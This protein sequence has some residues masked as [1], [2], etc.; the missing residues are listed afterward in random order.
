MTQ[1]FKNITTTDRID[2]GLLD[3]LDRDLTALTAMSGESDPSTIPTDA[4][5]DN[6]T[7]GT[8][9]LN[10]NVLIDYKNQLL[11][12]TTLAS[13]FQHLNTNLTAI[14]G[15]TLDVPCLIDTGGEVLSVSDYGIYAANAQI[16]G[17]TKTLAKKSII[18][19][20][21]IDDNSITQ[22]KLEIPLS[23][24]A[25]FKC[26]D[27]LYSGV[28]IERT[29]FLKLGTNYTLGSNSSNATYRNNAYYNLYVKL[30]AAASAVIR[31]YNG[32][33]VNKG[34]SAYDD[35]SNGNSVD[36][37]S[38]KQ[39]KSSIVFESDIPGDY[40]V[41][42]EFPGRYEV[43]CV[44]GGGGTVVAN[45]A[46]SNFGSST[47]AGG[48]SGAYAYAIFN[49]P[50]N[51][52]LEVSVGKKGEDVYDLVT[53]AGPDHYITCE[54]GGTSRVVLDNITLISG[55]GGVGGYTDNRHNNNNHASPSAG[56]GGTAYVDSSA[57]TYDTRNG[58]SGT[59]AHAGWDT[60]ISVK[61]GSSV[62]DQNKF[63]GKDYGRA[64]SGAA[65]PPFNYSFT[66]VGIGG[67]VKITYLGLPA[68]YELDAINIYIK[69]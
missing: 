24:E 7:V 34:A 69:Y 62:V 42:L 65:Y 3:L 2:T 16:I 53:G 23:E 11:N 56:D 45:A 37:P 58:N 67:Y 4:I 1:N 54:T 6:R 43:V 28:S 17:G 19:T 32:V 29:G 61:G 41:G 60:A 21:L 46:Y 10:G 25:Q 38:V 68:D 26:G 55:T 22:A 13:R 48:G 59:A 14:S 27:I 64:S 39:V 12:S 47:G 33:A 49:L 63:W 31:N 18:N 57:I 20:S 35:F 66:D 51:K 15:A 5:Y 52:T 40:Q 30:W 44:G 50:F 36:L 9:K 8:L